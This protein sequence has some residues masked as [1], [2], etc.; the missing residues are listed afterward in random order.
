MRIFHKNYGLGLV[1]K[2]YKCSHHK[3]SDKRQYA[4]VFK[5]L[6]KAENM[7]EFL[8]SKSFNVAF[9]F[10]IG[11]GIMCLLRPMCHGSECI[12]QKAPPLE[13]VN[14]STYQLGSKCYQFR[15]VTIDCPKD[16]VIEAFSVRTTLA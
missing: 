8:K 3:S 10:L 13:E 5:H 1:E 12:V 9:S 7:F 4:E 16:G 6:F 14:K 2:K 11:L 15:S